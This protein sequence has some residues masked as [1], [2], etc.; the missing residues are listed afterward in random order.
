MRVGMIPE[1]GGSSRMR[2]R[3]ETPKL[4]CLTVRVFKMLKSYIYML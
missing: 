4:Q 2:R 1:E 3:Y